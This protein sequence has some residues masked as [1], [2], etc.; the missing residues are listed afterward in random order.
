[1]RSRAGLYSP[2]MMG[3]SP[4]LVSRRWA[5]AVF[6]GSAALAFLLLALGKWSG[7]LHGDTPTWA[8]IGAVVFVD[9]AHV[10]ATAYRVYLDPEEMRRRAGLYV[11]VP[12]FAYVAGVL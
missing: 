8:W 12:L 5:L 3:A 9:V 7:A 1:M 2:R 6:G 10:W 11:A 4:W